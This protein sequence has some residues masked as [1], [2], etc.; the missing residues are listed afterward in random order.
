MPKELL[1][2]D[3]ELIFETVCVQFNIKLNC[4]VVHLSFPS[5]FHLAILEFKQLEQWTLLSEWKNKGNVA[6]WDTKRLS[7]HVDA[8]RVVSVRFNFKILI[9][10]IFSLFD[11]LWR[12][13]P[14]CNLLIRCCM[15][16]TVDFAV[17]AASRKLAKF[18]RFKCAYPR[19]LTA[20]KWQA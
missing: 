14:L 13:R 19:E 4:F 20:N 10:R 8:A 3:N 9:L 12:Y 18:G 1:A 6:C 17:K 2:A 15:T 11:P 7:F 16:I 5:S